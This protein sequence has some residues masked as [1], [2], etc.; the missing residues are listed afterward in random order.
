MTE[1]QPTRLRDLPAVLLRNK[2]LQLF[3]ALLACLELY[4][5]G[6]VPAYITTQKGIETQAIA[7]NAALKYKFTV[8]LSMVTQVPIG[9]LP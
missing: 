3:V 5:H 4:N 1:Q 8:P 7:T 6:A 2:W 9:W